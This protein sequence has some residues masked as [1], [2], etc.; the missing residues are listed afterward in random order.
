MKE[1]SFSSKT[2]LV[3][4]DG[5]KFNVTFGGGGKNGN[6]TGM[7]IVA[8]I[9]V[10]ALA[11]LCAGIVLMTKTKSCEDEDKASTTAKVDASKEQCKYSDEASRIGLDSFLKKVQ[12]AHFKLYP[13]NIGWH[14]NVTEQMIRQE[15]RAYDPSPSKIKERTDTAISLLNEVN[16]KVSFFVSQRFSF[17]ICLQLQPLR[18]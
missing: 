2:E 14:P 12:N 13:E 3:D 8:V 16:A 4:E 1:P 6:R 7:I 9:C 11:C 15:Y 17:Q 10:I 5:K 18:F